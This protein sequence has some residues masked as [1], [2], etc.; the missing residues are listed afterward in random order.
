MLEG[1]LKPSEIAKLGL[2]VN[3]KGKP[4]YSF[5]IKLIKDGKLKAIPWTISTDSNGYE[6]AYYVVPISE[7]K[8]Y[9]D[10]FKVT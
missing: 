7:I 1:M 8:R 3:S 6:K 2:I 9:Q 10:T 4:S 5:V